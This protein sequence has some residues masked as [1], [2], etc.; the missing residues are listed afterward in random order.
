M[1]RKTTNPARDLAQELDAV[2]VE[3]SQILTPFVVDGRFSAVADIDDAVASSKARLAA[4]AAANDV[5]AFDKATTAFDS[6]LKRA[7]EAAKSG[8]APGAAPTA[9]QPPTV[10]PAALVP[11][12]AGTADPSAPTSGADTTAVII[13]RPAPSASLAGV[14]VAVSGHEARISRVEEEVEAARAAAEEPTFQNKRWAV[15]TLLTFIL[16]GGGIGWLITDRTAGLVVG[17]ALG[18]IGAF[19]VGLGTSRGRREV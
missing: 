8:A 10:P 1:A 17:C 18:V 16:A 9:P 2:R 4:T 13:P 11:S 3:Y 19:M 5:V 14:S 12:T 6:A 7:V 15:A